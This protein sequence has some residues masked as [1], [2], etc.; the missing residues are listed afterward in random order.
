MV[1]WLDGWSKSFIFH[2][3]SFIIKWLEEGHCRF[4]GGLGL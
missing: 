3:K 4:Q 1:K 2:L